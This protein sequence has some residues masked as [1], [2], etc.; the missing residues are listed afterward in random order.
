MATPT[1]PLAQLPGLSSTHAQT[2]TQLGLTGTDHLRR[3][4]SSLARRQALAK[5]MQVPLRYVTKWV[6]L[7]NLAQVPAVG[8]QFSGLL[9]HAGVVSVP[10]LAN[11]TAQ[12]LYVRLR[13][14]H[15]ATLQRNDLSPTA[16]QVSLWIQQA[17][18]IV[19]AS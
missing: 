1:Y 14:L 19:K 2:M 7:A 9:L 13:R 17:K 8:C 11:C 3:Y 4:G 5:K 6:V 16:D 10:Q 12:E 15:V 18:G